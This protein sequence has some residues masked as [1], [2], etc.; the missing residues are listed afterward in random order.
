MTKPGQAGHDASASTHT[1][2]FNTNWVNGRI[3]CVRDRSKGVKPTFWSTTVVARQSLIGEQ[4]TDELDEDSPL[5]GR[6]SLTASLT[7]ERTAK[8]TA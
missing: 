3:L 7:A 4:D 6:G 5:A 1:T 8:P 2:S